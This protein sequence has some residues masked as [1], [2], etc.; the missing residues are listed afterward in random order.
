MSVAGNRPVL[1]YCHPSMDKLAKAIV[2][3]LATKV[4]PKKEKKEMII[5]FFLAFFQIEKFS[6]SQT[7]E[8]LVR[9]RFF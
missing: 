6:Q 1:L 3:D 9:V 2:D 4:R 7:R 8:V 5:P